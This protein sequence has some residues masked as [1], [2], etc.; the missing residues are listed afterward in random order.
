[1]QPLSDLTVIDISLTL[2][3]PYAT[4]LLQQ[5][6]ANVISIEPPNGDPLRH[7]EPKLRDGSGELYTLLNRGKRTMTV[8]LKDDRGRKFLIDLAEEADVFVEG[9]RPGVVDSLGVGPQTL[10]E[11]NDDLIYCSLSGFG[12]SGPRSQQPA[13]ALN[14]EGLAGLLDPEDPAMPRFPVSDFAGGLM[15]GFATLA[16]LRARDRGEGG[17]YV[18]LS[19]FETIASWNA[20]HMPWADDPDHEFDRDPLV[21]GEYPCYNTYETADG[22]HLTLGIMEPSFW[23]ELCERLDRPELTD[24]QFEPGGRDSDAYEEL[25]RRFAERPLNEWVDMLSDD[26]PVAAVQSN[27]EAIADSQLDDADRVFAFDVD[28]GETLRDFDFPVDF[29]NE[30]E[31]DDGSSVDSFLRSAG[32]DERSIESLSDEGVLSDDF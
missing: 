13:H 1:M 28:T 32:Y 27:A 19:L 16:A 30:L 11:R 10:T 3:G 31:R 14:Y 17:Q 4:K 26:L 18:D 20:W 25:Q 15:L 23:K 9:F 2:P 6:G 24:D 22:R 7:R 8:D 21:G 29:E 12:Q 5:L